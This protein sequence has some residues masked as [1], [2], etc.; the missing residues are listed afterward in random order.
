MK[1]VSFF[2]RRKSHIGILSDGGATI[3]NLSVAAPKLPND[4]TDIIATGT[5]AGVGIGFKPPKF[6]K[7]GDV[8]TL[9]IDGLGVLENTV[10]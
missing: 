1:L 10:A 9:A 2:H 3:V 4:M 6:L 8:C 5:P 7:K